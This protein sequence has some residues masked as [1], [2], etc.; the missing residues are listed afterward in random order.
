MRGLQ[1]PGRRKWWLGIMMASAGIGE[2][3]S[4]G[5]GEDGARTLGSDLPRTTSGGALHARL[6]ELTTTCSALVENGARSED[7]GDP[8]WR[9]KDGSPNRAREEDGE[10]RPHR[11]HAYQMLHQRLAAADRWPAGHRPYLGARAAHVRR[12]VQ[13]K[14]AL[15]STI[16][17]EEA[18]A[19]RGGR[20]EQAPDETPEWT[21]PPCGAV[22]CQVS[23]ILFNKSLEKTRSCVGLIVSICL[24]P[25]V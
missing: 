11:W 23:N 13:P 4:A 5:Q 2:V 7:G 19:T 24:Q 6:G 22:A 20:E 14:G 1:G 21:T 12:A 10:C 25:L 15:G 16:E 17:R 8:F 9:Q 18:S 3:P